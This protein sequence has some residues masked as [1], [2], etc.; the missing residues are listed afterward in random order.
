[1]AAH[2]TAQPAER[3]GSTQKAPDPAAASD[4]IAKAR[5]RRRA[6]LQHL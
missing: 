5:E 6:I 3:L 4:L 2:P 1:M